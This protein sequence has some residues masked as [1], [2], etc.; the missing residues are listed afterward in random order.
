MAK[1]FDAIFVIANDLQAINDSIV[2]MNMFTDLKQVLNSV[3]KGCK[4]LKTS[5]ERHF[6]YSRRY[7]RYYIYGTIF[8]L[9]NYNTAKGPSKLQDSEVFHHLAFCSKN[10]IQF[11]QWFDLIAQ[12]CKHQSNLQ[13]W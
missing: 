5:Y 6:G 4:R 12:I 8:I 3:I 9:G 7:C 10:D 11:F 2:P 13:S 1:E